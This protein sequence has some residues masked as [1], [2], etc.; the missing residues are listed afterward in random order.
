MLQTID[1]PIISPTQTQHRQLCVHGLCVCASACL[2][3]RGCFLHQSL[4]LL[5]AWVT[6]SEDGH[7]LLSD[8]LQ[9]IQAAADH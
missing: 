4:G 3:Q 7:R 2:A 6:L 1:L 9:S 5:E 8:E